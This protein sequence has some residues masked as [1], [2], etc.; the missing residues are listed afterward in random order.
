MEEVQSAPSQS[1]HPE[2]PSIAPRTALA[3][4]ATLLV[5]ASA[6]PAIRAGLAAYSPFH[7]ALLRFMVGSAVFLALA[8]RRTVRQPNFRDWPRL[9]LT[10]AIGITAYHFALNY[11]EMTVSAA[12]A[13][14][15]IN[16]GPIF[17][18][19]LALPLLGEKLRPMAWAGIRAVTSGA[20]A[21]RM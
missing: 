13:S 8:L 14:F 16:L 2:R 10:A 21:G 9:L 5:W 18:A 12:S 1:N 20:S 19:L 3:I 15:I 4:S 7:L 11:G 17:T 6:F